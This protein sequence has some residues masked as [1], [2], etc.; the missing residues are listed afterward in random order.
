VEELISAGFV[1]PSASPYAMP[2]LLVPKKD[3]TW[4]ICI[5]TRAVNKVTIK[6]RFPIHHGG[7]CIYL[8]NYV[9]PVFFPK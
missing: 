6:F 7:A 8:T 1:R 5:D 9:V 2:A 3:G 4:R